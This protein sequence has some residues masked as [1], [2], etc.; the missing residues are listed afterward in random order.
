MRDK[1]P[2]VRDLYDSLAP[3]PDDMTL[4]DVAEELSGAEHE[5]AAL[6]AS[7][8]DLARTLAT[9]LRK[10]GIPAPPVVKDV[11]ETLSDTTT[12]PRDETL[13]R[14]RA[15]SRIADLELRRP[16]PDS[17]EILEAARKGP[18]ELSKE[19]RALLDAEAEGLRKEIDAEHDKTK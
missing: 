13:A 5:A 19:D 6:R 3:D 10:A 11:I 9:D 4:E 8:A 12:L 18:G 1:K 7:V 15:A 16:V 2:D 17:Y 14:S